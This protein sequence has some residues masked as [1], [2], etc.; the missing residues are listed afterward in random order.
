MSSPAARPRPAPRL[1]TFD[2]FG[3]VLD[4]RTGLESAVGRRLSDAEFDRV[5]DRQGELERT[6]APYAGIVAA[7]LREVLGVDGER[8]ARIG[9]EIGRWPLFPDSREALRRLRKIAPCVAM[10]NSDRAHGEAVRERLP[11]IDGWLCAEEVR[12]YK[13]DPRFWEEVARA[14]GVPFGAAWWH[15]SAYVDYDL[16]VARRFGLTTVFVERPHSRPG[17]ADV[18]VQDLDALAAIVEGA[19]GTA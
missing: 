5:I 15:V 18:V 12:V 7:S 10:T 16:A 1:L 11:G 8:A 17:P 4:W 19:A 2:I 13:P 6:F 9:A 14:R 3:T